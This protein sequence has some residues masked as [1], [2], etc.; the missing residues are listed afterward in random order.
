MGEA[1]TFYH[2]QPLAKPKSK[3]ERVVG[4]AEDGR[5]VVALREAGAD[6][7]TCETVFHLPEADRLARACL[8]GDERALTTPGLARIFAASIIVLSRA[9]YQ[10]GA[11]QAQPADGG[12][13]NDG[14]SDD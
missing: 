14:H 13:D 2:I 10:A 8:A 6:S 7:G 4:E 11:L 9:A 5:I 1:V 12:S 3:Q